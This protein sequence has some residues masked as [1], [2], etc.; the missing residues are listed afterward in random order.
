MAV[1]A[2]TPT[3]EHVEQDDMETEQFDLRNL[4]C[5]RPDQID[6][7]QVAVTYDRF[8]D[9]LM[10]HVHGKNVASISVPVRK[11]DYI[12]VSPDGREFL[13]FQIEG[14]LAQAVKD[15]PR[16]IEMLNFAELRGITP[17]E[18]QALRDETLSPWLRISATFRRIFTHNL[19]ERRQQAVG[20]F[21]EKEGK[22]LKLQAA[23]C[24]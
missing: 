12:L 2:N 18:V 17:A 24:S 10:L 8:S 1:R 13:G 16:M 20:A 23:A 3:D 7:S 11:Y 9:T 4:R 14:F 21:L 22:G 6:I 5:P 19:Q 15:E